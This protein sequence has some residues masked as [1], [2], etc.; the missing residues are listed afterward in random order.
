MWQYGTDTAVKHFRE[1]E[2]MKSEVFP[3][4]TSGINRNLWLGKEGLSGKAGRAC[5]NS[6]REWPEER[7]S[8]ERERKP[9]AMSTC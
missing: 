5:L 9:K 7:N 3:P 2:G 1:K 8:R 4:D 6:V